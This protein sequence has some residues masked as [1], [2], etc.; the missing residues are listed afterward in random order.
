MLVAGAAYYFWSNEQKKQKQ[1]KASLAS[2]SRELLVS[3]SCELLA[4]RPPTFTENLPGGVTLEMVKISAGSFLMG[5]DEAEVEKRFNQNLQEYPALY[6]G[7]GN[8]EKCETPLHRVNLQEFY[9]GKYLITQGQYKAVM[10]ENPS[11]YQNS[12][13]SP[14]H[15]V[16]RVSFNDAQLFCKKLSEI[17]GKNYR[18]P[19]EAEWEYA[20]RAGTT[21]SFYFGD[22]EDE[23]G[24]YAWCDQNLVLAEN[25][26]QSDTLVR[27]HPVGQKKPNNWG[28]YDMHGLIREMCEDDWH[29]SYANKSKD[30]KENGNIAW[31]DNN[32]PIN[33]RICVLRSSNWGYGPSASRSAVRAKGFIGRGISDTGFRVCIFPQP[34]QNN[35]Q[36]IATEAPS[37][38]QPQLNTSK[39]ELKSKSQSQSNFSK[40]NTEHDQ[41]AEYWFNQG[42]ELEDDT[43]TQEE[44]IIALK[45][46]IEIEPDYIDAWFSLG[47]V[48]E[49][50]D[51]Y[52]EAKIAYTKVIELQPKHAEGWFQLGEVLYS[53]EHDLE[54]PENDRKNPENLEKVLL[55]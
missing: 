7:T 35:Q 5:T 22:N 13:D 11:C 33:E 20:C 42:V 12:K 41:N 8:P 36:L 14:Y 24:D 34:Q 47:E 43:R 4:T 48:L 16:E 44:A 55:C 6:S 1:Q 54:N 3:K 50:V 45:K 39:D 38:S 46:A 40:N 19:T 17:T 26:E 53:L 25:Q 9:L 2:K 49:Y 18:L 21:T 28:L 15:P 10:G 52:E 31:L 23:R 30:L 37:K 29:D 32:K 27:T 51:R